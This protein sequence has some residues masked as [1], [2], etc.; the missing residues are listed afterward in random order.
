MPTVELKAPPSKYRVV[1]VD[2]F[3]GTDWLHGDYDSLSEAT[4]EAE[5]KGGIMLKT[6]VYD[7]KGRH[8]F[9]AGTF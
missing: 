6:H 5:K 1:A 4:D 8:V 7:D 3:D 9:E 2:T